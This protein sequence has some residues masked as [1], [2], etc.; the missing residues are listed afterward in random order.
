[1]GHSLQV[2]PYFWICNHWSNGRWKACVWFHWTNYIIAT[3]VWHDLLNK[4]LTRHFQEILAPFS[5]SFFEVLFSVWF[6]EV[7]VIVMWQKLIGNSVPAMFLM[8]SGSSQVFV[9]IRHVSA[10]RWRVFGGTRKHVHG[11][12]LGRGL[13]SLRQLFLWKA[14]STSNWESSPAVILTFV[15]L[16]SISRPEVTCKTKAL[17]SGMNFNLQRHTPSLRITFQWIQIYRYSTD[18]LYVGTFRLVYLHERNRLFAEVCS[19]AWQ[20]AGSD[21]HARISHWISKLGGGAKF[22]QLETFNMPQVNKTIGGQFMFKGNRGRAADPLDRG[23]FGTLCQIN[24]LVNF[25]SIKF[26]NR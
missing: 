26:W 5:C 15:N 8:H 9:K 19:A 24:R 13:A 21:V 3:K 14:N 17:M 22:F 4:L 11:L 18:V 2:F 16:D 10:W 7:T 6:V 25:F 20:E 1:M 12:V 23:D